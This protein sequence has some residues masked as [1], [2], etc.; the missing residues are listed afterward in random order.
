MSMDDKNKEQILLLH[1]GDLVSTVRMLAPARAIREHHRKARITLL[2]GDEFESLLKYCP[3]F[4]EVQANL[5]QAAQKNWFERMKAARNSSYD[6]VYDL[7]SGEQGAKLKGAMRFS[8]TK[9]IDVAPHPKDTGHPVDRVAERIGKA[10]L[11]PET[12]PPGGAPPPNA[13][14][15]DFVAKQSR[16]VDPAYFGL[17]G[18]FALFVPAGDDVP[19]ALRWPKERWASLAHEVLALGIE[20]AI[21]GGPN[22]REVGRYVAHVTPGARDLTGRANLVQLTGLGRHTGFAFGENIGLLHLMVAAGS[23]AV[24][25]HPGPEAPYDEAPRGPATTVLMHAPTLAQI[26][27]PEAL[28]AMRVAGGFNRDTQAA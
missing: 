17:Q 15:V 26:S 20:P 12:Y 16:T 13:D 2:C 24:V 11:G 27:V 7:G 14:W 4:N 28:Q 23:P 1:D 9:W 8:K 18:D 3:Y 22:A 10:G 6:F 25:F 5:G 19:P 21:I